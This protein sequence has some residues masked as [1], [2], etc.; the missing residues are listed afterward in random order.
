MSF[1]CTDKDTLIAY[2][3]GECDAATRET[4]DAHLAACPACAD[5]VAGFG[6]VRETLSQWAPPDR[7]GGFRLVRDEATPASAPA[8]VLRPARWWQTTV[9]ALARVAA[10]VLLVA[11]GAALA[12][13]EVRY[14]KDGFL[15]RTGWQKPAPA[16]VQ[17]AAQPAQPPPA[18]AARPASAVPSSN[19][20]AT[21]D[22]A[23]WRVEMATMQRQLRDE[24]RQ[25]VA[26]VKVSAPATLQAAA[27]GG[28]DEN[29]FMQRVYTALEES[30]RRQQFDLVSRMNRLVN[31]LQAQRTL[32]LRRI[33]F[34]TLPQ[35]L[36]QQQRPK[37][38]MLFDVSLKK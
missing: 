22:P 30:E 18:P 31:D 19:A 34:D 32:D 13:L 25:Q 15:V 28:V 4:V 23:P 7:V 38:P 24:F 17:M 16:V 37:N 27:N 11:G 36:P 35:G 6:V 5:E 9:P 1:S 12:N 2:I 10:A 8:K 26:A 20:G 33:G 14:D 21:D 3:Y 29:R